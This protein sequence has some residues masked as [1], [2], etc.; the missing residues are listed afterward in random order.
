MVD[1]ERTAA[2]WLQEARRWAEEGGH[3]AA[4]E[5]GQK[6]L[7]RWPG[8][9]EVLYFL[10]KQSEDLD[11]LAVARTYFEQILAENPTWND[12][13]AARALE[14]VQRRLESAD[15]AWWTCQTSP[16]AETFFSSAIWLRHRLSSVERSLQVSSTASARWLRGVILDALGNRH[17]STTE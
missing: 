10:G 14:G 15:E 1:R 4:L 6:A 9:P 17:T 13:A 5:C 12:G 8:D 3:D 11:R 16:S 7:A 2:E